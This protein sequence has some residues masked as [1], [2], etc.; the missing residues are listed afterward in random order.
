MDKRGQITYMQVRLV[1]MA[2]EKWNISVAEAAG[3]FH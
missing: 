2:T 1:R 3:I